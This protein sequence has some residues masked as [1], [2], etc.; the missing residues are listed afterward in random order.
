MHRVL[1][2]HQPLLRVH[3]RARRK[4]SAVDPPHRLEPSASRSYVNCATGAAATVAVIDCG[5]PKLLY[6]CA[7][8]VLPSVV[9][10][11]RPLALSRARRFSACSNTRDSVQA[12]HQ[13]HGV[14]R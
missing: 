13:R 8:L 5:S 14:L 6:V 10:L 3:Q 1:D 9:P 7:V 2:G 12:Q 4:A 11:S